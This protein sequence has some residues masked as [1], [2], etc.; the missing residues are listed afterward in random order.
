MEGVFD[1]FHIRR[2]DF[3]YKATRIPAIEIYNISKNVIPEGSTVYIGTDERDKTFFDDLRK[4]YN[5]LFL[6]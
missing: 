1:S 5:V 3:Q 6:R 4:H 2:G